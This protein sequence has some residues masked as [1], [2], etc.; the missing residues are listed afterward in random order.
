MNLGCSDP[1]PRIYKETQAIRELLKHQPVEHS[2]ER[3]KLNIQGQ[4]QFIPTSFVGPADV[5]STVTLGWTA[6]SQK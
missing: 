2:G 3:C 1:A 4:G 5:C 6:D